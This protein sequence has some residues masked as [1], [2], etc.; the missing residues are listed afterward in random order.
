MQCNNHP[1]RKA[2]YI[3]CS[4][5]APLCTDCAEEVKGGG[6][7]VCFQCAIVRSVSEVGHGLLDKQEKVAEKKAKQSKQWGPFQYFTVVAS[8]MILVMWCVI[9]F[10][11]QSA[12]VLTADTLERGK[13]GRVL[14]FMVDGALKRY[15]YNEGN[16]YPVNLLALVPKYLKIKEEQV[17]CLDKLSYEKDTEKHYRLSLA[18]SGESGMKIILTPNGLEY[19]QPSEG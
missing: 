5:N 17:H 18:D 10:G 9:I 3:C 7:Y 19:V 13:A 11:G 2:E 16:Q 15:A 12:P 6:G 4:C 1:D 8:V 14:L